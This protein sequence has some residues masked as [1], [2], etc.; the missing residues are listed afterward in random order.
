MAE[1]VEAIAISTWQILEIQGKPVPSPYASTPLF[2]KLFEKLAK[3]PMDA[4]IAPLLDLS[5]VL[6]P[7]YL[8]PVD[9]RFVMERLRFGWYRS[10]MALNADLQRLSRIAA[11]SGKPHFVQAFMLISMALTRAGQEAVGIPGF[12]TRMY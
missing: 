6:G 8:E 12:P 9:L 2:A 4:A 3:L 5:G 1:E 10:T 7:L 11:D